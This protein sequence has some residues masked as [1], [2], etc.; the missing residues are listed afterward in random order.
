MPDPSFSNPKPVVHLVYTVPLGK[1][2]LKRA[3]IRGLRLTHVTP[4]HRYANEALIDWQHPIRAPHSITYNLIRAIRARGYTVR[5]YSLYE[6]GVIRRKPG[7][8]LIAAPLPTGILGVTRERKDDRASITSR[9]IREYPGKQN[10][11][12][13]PYAHDEQY[14]VFA[15]DL[16][17]ENNRAGGGSIFIG[18]KIWEKDWESK[19]PFADLGALR[20]VHVTSMGVNAAEYPFVKS[21]FNPKGKR[22]YLYIGHTAWYKNTAE[23]ERIAERMPEYEFAHIGGGEVKGWKKLANFAPLTPEFVARLAEEFDIFVNV[24]TADPQATTIVEQ[25]CFGF[26][27]ACT[28]ETGY[29]YPTLTE[30]RTND[31]EY[32]VRTL[33]HL[34]HAD[35]DELLTC[36]RVNRQTAEERHGWGQFTDRILD[37]TEIRQTR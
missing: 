4:L 16:I 22:R 26:A 35:E 5:L 29:D 34:Q 15:K 37:F 27:V 33:L 19:S 8:V 23:L 7:D 2:L 36:S 12:I 3:I 17:Q 20:K 9:T 1:T 14:S 21:R 28:P 25:M 24:S 13:M 10:Y 6:Q 18:G 31:T 30:L 11:I 32:N